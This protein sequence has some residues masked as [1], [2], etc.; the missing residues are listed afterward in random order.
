MSINKVMISGNTTRDAELRVTPGGL[1]ILNFGV[2]VNERRRNAHNEWEDY[3]NFV[4]CS[5]FGRRAEALAQYLT[6]G[7]KVAIE[8][9]LHYGSW[10]DRE[11]GQRRSKLTVYVDELEFLSARSNSSGNNPNRSQQSRPNTTQ[12]TGNYHQP[13][14][15]QAVQESFPGSAVYDASDIPP[16]AY[17]DDDIPF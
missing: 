14:A 11:T 13:N 16:Q 12:T 6:K 8:G 9:H 15:N 17:S 5:L 1:N 2:A 7:T 10:D 4:E 3:A